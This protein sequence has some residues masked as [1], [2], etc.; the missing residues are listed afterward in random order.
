MRSK[1]LTWHRIGKKMWTASPLDIMHLFS[2]ALK[3]HCK[4]KKNQNHKAHQET[5]QVLSKL[6]RK[7]LPEQILPGR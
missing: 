4:K 6:R 7:Q 5:I 3:K 2:S 1:A